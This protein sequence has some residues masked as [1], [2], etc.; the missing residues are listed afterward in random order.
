MVTEAARLVDGELDDSLRR[1]CQPDVADDRSVAATDGVLDRCPNPGQLDVH[2]LED[3]AGDRRIRGGLADETEQE[4]L[5]ADVV[6]VEPQCL[7]LGKGEHLAGAVR[8][9]VEAIHS[10]SL[11]LFLSLTASRLELAAAHREW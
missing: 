2:E 10:R 8:E 4:V 11:G 6:V 9:L 7:I 5:R 1:E 3:L